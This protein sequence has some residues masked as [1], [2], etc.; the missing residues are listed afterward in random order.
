M[1]LHAQHTPPPPPR[2]QRTIPQSQRVEWVW[3]CVPARQ[4]S[5]LAPQPAREAVRRPGS[6]LL[7]GVQVPVPMALLLV[8]SR[9]TVDHAPVL[10]VAVVITH[11][12]AQR[13][14]PVQRIPLGPTLATLDV[15][16]GG[17]H[18]R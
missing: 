8:C 18:P 17:I 2:A 13:L 5:P 12:H 4:P 1:R 6:V 11:Q 3:P 10:T 14:P 9:G 16:R 7:Q 15:D